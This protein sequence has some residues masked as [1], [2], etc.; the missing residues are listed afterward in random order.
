MGD[1]APLNETDPLTKKT[2]K[3][4]AK[5]RRQAAA[6]IG[7]GTAED[8]P[9]LTAAKFDMPITEVEQKTKAVKKASRTA[10]TATPPIED[11]PMAG[12]CGAPSPSS[13]ITELE[14][15][16]KNAVAIAVASDKKAAALSQ[17]S[18]EEQEKVANSLLN[19]KKVRQD[20][21][22]KEGNA[23]SSES[24]KKTTKKQKRA[25]KVDVG[26][27]D[28]GV[29]ANSK[30]PAHHTNS[31]GKTT[32]ISLLEGAPTPTAVKLNSAIIDAEKKIR[33]A[34][35]ANRVASPTATK[36]DRPSSCSSSIDELE[37]KA[38]PSVAA[39]ASDKEM[40]ALSPISREE[41]EKAANSL[42]SGKNSN[43]DVSKKK[44]RV[45][46]SESRKNTTK[47]KKKA[48]EVDVE[49]QDQLVAAASVAK[50]SNKPTDLQSPTRAPVHHTDFIGTYLSSPTTGGEKEPMISAVSLWALSPT[51]HQLTTTPTPLVIT[52]PVSSTSGSGPAVSPL[53]ANALGDTLRG[54]LKETKK[55]G[56][57]ASSSSSFFYCPCHHS[58]H[59][60][61]G[62]CCGRCVYGTVQVDVTA[63]KRSPQAP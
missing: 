29:A 61:E 22:E 20:V 39:A 32:G 44:S 43:K 11:A 55:G 41:Q 59:G 10:R 46:S 37:K 34:K 62:H 52:S 16:A 38:N 56:R 3:A 15:N 57:G 45:A 47:K 36:E 12:E 7:M 9:T 26:P 6:T 58:R 49:A 33:A 31:I 13:S 48:L 4:V 1:T 60:R 30:L 17:N 40:V 19:S 21:S 8:A 27:Q 51:A 2:S 54:D 5:E 35:K 63:S 18:R 25:L 23:A 50:S 53:V 14:K 28:Q 42:L 24:R